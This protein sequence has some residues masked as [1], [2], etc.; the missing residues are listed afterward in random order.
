[1]AH[2]AQH[3]NKLLALIRQPTNARAAFHHDNPQAIFSCDRLGS[4]NGWV[5]SQKLISQNPN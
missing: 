2:G 4:E 1:V 5:A 3:Q